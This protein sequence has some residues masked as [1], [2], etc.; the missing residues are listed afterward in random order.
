MTKSLTN[1][2]I[3]SI[4]YENFGGQLKHQCSA[5]PKVDRRTGEFFIFGYDNRAPKVYLTVLDKAKKMKSHIT[6]PI[7]TIR[8]I[9]DFSITK[10][11]CIVP[12]FPLEFIKEKPFKEGGFIYKFDK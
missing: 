4:G 7:T 10:D 3:K 6:I 5:H 1:F 9:H 11:Y 2:N 12:D 8:M